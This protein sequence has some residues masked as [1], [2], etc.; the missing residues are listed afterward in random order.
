M[1]PFKMSRG[2][3]G[4]FASGVNSTSRVIISS[5]QGVVVALAALG[6]KGP[7]IAICSLLFCAPVAGGEQNGAAAP[8]KIGQTLAEVI[9]ILGEPRGHVALGRRAF[10]SYEI[11]EV[12]LLDGVVNEVDFLSP[13]EAE[14]QAQ[15]RRRR[16]ERFEEWVAERERVER[17]A[18][19]ESRREA[20]LARQQRNYEEIQAELERLRLEVARQTGR[21]E[22]VIAATAAGR[23]EAPRNLTTVVAGRDAVVVQEGALGPGGTTVVVAPP[24]RVERRP[25]QE[26]RRDA[27]APLR[28]SRPLPA[29]R[30]PLLH[31]PLRPHPPPP[32]FSWE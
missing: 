31:P 2:T 6:R 25:P 20:E 32:P 18:L 19:D 5:I 3:R 26:I 16:Q 11:G 28:P 27:P 10:L 24:R 7:F 13:E 4:K 9:D 8:V 21:V 29:H 17:E 14:R 22:G 23:H 30:P 1:N 12:R 15:A